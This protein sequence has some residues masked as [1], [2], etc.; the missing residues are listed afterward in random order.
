MYIV[1]SCENFE[2]YCN[3]CK[4]SILAF[5]SNQ[6]L[7]LDKVSWLQKRIIPTRYI[8]VP[9]PT[10]RNSLDHGCEIDGKTGN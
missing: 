4:N 3:A 10:D 6:L 9:V 7:N 8:Y 5:I 2:H 1:L